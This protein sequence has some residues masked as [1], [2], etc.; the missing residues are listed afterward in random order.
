MRNRIGLVNRS[1]ET[2]DDRVLEINTA[3]I[4]FANNT[5]RAALLRIDL[6]RTIAQYYSKARRAALV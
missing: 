4:D 1:R 3:Q 6:L 5:V 2:R